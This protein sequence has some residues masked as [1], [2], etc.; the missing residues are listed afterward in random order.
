MSS[1]FLTRNPMA[2]KEQKGAPIADKFVYDMNKNVKHGLLDCKQTYTL[3]IAT[4]TGGVVMDQKVIKELQEGK[5]QIKS[6]LEEAALKA[7]ELT[8]AL[9]LKGYQ[10]YE[11]H[12]RGASIVCVGGFDS[13]GTPR[14]DGRIEI[15][16]QAYELMQIFGAKT[17]PTGAVQPQTVVGIPLDIQP[18]LIYV[19]RRSI[20]ADYAGP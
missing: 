2:P 19:P 9:R 1:A 20:S 18:T 14:P 3:K 5:R 7:H 11:F 15:N 12:D 10:A 8:E 6:R 17:S 16:P 13:V 4:F